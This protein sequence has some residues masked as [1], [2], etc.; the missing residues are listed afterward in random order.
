MCD[1]TITTVQHVE[2]CNTRVL[3]HGI[4]EQKIVTDDSEDIWVLWKQ[5][6]HTWAFVHSFLFVGL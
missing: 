6:D 5:I 1:T 2:Q 4:K 3:G